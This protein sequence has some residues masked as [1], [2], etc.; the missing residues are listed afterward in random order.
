[1]N[2]WLCNMPKA[3]FHLHIDGSLQAQRMLQ[4]AQKNSKSLPYT[5]VEV[6]EIFYNYNNLYRLFDIYYVRSR[7]L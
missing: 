3:E 5:T 1:M 7:C 6:I 2:D 4:L